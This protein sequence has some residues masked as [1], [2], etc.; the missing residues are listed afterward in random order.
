MSWKFPLQVC[1]I[2]IALTISASCRYQQDL[3]HHIHVICNRINNVNGAYN[4][5]WGRQSSHSWTFL[6]GYTIAEYFVFKLWFS[7]RTVHRKC[8]STKGESGWVRP[9]L[10][11]NWAF[12]IFLVAVKVF[13]LFMLMFSSGFNCSQVLTVFV[14]FWFRIT[15]YSGDRCGCFPCVNCYCCLDWWGWKL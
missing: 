1:K 12:G 5:E 11:E 13:F 15:V 2:T 8:M 10:F 14:D 3:V 6:F 9:I 7:A 4:Y